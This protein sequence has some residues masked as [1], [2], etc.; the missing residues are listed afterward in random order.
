MAMVPMNLARVSNLLRTGVAG[1]AIA[2]TQRSMLEVSNQLST[3]K[4]LSVP[5]DD[6]GDAAIAQQLRKTIER[7]EAYTTNINQASNQLGLADST[8]GDVTDLLRQAQTL[9]SANVG[10]DVTADARQGAAAVVRSIYSQVLSLSNTQSQGMYLFAGD[11]SSAVPFVEDGGGVKFVGSTRVLSNIYDDGT[12]LP[13]MVDGAEA[14]GA[15]SSRVEGTADLTPRMTAATR[16]AD[17][18]GALGAG[19]G[20]GSIRISNGSTSAVVDLTDVKS[21]GDVINAIN[22]AGVG[23]ITAGLGMGGQRLQVTG[24]ASETITIKDVGGGTA[25]TDL[26]I[27]NPAGG[28]AGTA[29]VG[30]MVAPKLTP[31]TRLSDLKGGLGIDTAN[32]MTITNGQ[33]SATI[34]L[35]GAATMED[36]LNAINGANVGVRASVNDAGTGINI[37]NATQNTT[38]TISEAG[39]TL[40]SDLGVR[41]FHPGTELAELNAGA[42]VRTVAGADFQIDTAGG[43]AFGVDVSGAT[44]VQGVIDAINAAGGGAVAAGFAANGNGITITDNTV[45]GGALR[46]TPV[47]FSNAAADLGI[48]RAAV[49][50]TIAGADVDAVQASGVFSNLL[51][52]AASLEKGDQAGIT[53]AGGSLKEDESRVIRL[54]GR[55]GARV[56]ELDSRSNRLADEDVA[57]KSLLSQLED[58]DYTAAISKFQTLQT[59]LEA[60]L[61]TASAT[62]KMS[63]MDFLG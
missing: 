41:S 56:R 60:S 36:L 58:V 17:L 38:M 59:A 57:T 35:A 46:V 52:L 26:G 32:G 54:R 44:T 53:V 23:G 29:I 63:L 10:S 11:K 1:A 4:R 40:A 33:K 3:G 42:G 21:V 34:N 47:N 14:F 43:T 24:L 9:A 25:A 6:P 48:T 37:L 61:R 30:G 19:V 49:G 45:G 22:A 20:G 55:T 18:G 62:D 2:R 15:L 5:S 8:L 16:L 31:F 27:S 12:V 7:R 51:K 39:G 13:F 50:N 28:G